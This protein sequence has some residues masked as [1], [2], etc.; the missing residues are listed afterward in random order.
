M[1][2]INK[3]MLMEFEVIINNVMLFLVFCGLL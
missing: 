2:K 3:L 1:I